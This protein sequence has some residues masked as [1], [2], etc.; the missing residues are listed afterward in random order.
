MWDYV[1]SGFWLLVSLGGVIPADIF[2][3]AVLLLGGVAI[4]GNTLLLQE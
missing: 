1:W 2:W 3:P 4:L